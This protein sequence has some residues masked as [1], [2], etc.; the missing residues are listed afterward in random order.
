[1]FLQT[2]DAVVAAGFRLPQT[3][4]ELHGVRPD[5]LQLRVLGRALGMWDGI[6]PSE[7]WEGGGGGGQGCTGA[8]SVSVSWVG[9]S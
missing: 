7:V 2:N 8:G 4:Y 9:C 1:M 6:M 3:L 5:L